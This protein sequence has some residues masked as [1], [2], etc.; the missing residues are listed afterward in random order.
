MYTLPKLLNGQYLLTTLHSELP[1]SI[2]YKATQKDL[3]RE[4]R[5]KS[6][7]REFHTTDGDARFFADAEA[8]TLCRHAFISSPLE[9]FEAEGTWHLSYESWNGEPLDILSVN[10]RTLSPLQ[11]CVLMREM[12]H[13]ILSLD[14]QRIANRPMGMD[15]IYL[16]SDGSFRINNPAMGG[17]RTAE[18]R[19]ALIKAIG[20][21]ILR[22][23]TPASVTANRIAALALR[24]VQTQA[25]SALTA[26]NF[27]E[28]ISILQYQMGFK[29]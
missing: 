28:E 2:I 27:A 19:D 20:S 5:V 24:M 10:K 14:A 7:K 11:C 16:R 9:L 12:C 29:D 15:D 22:L 8:Q 1:E 23:I 13:L 21:W 4:V 17:V 18:M 26:A 6:L 3:R 25:C